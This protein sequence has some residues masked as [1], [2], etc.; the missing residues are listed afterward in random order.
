[1]S[2]YLTK[3]DLM[4]ALALVDTA[5]LEIERCQSLEVKDLEL[6][7]VILT[8]LNNRIQQYEEERT[9]LFSELENAESLAQY[10]LEHFQAA[11]DELTELKA[12]VSKYVRSGRNA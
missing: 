3:N 7:Y 6:L 4:K 12:A 1:M 5:A 10:Y 9:R 8:E 11:E 2:V